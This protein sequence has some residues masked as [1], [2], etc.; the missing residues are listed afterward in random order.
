MKTL[1]LVIACTVFWVAPAS[2]KESAQLL[3]V[4]D[5]DSLLVHYGNEARQVRL[6]GVDAPEGRQEYGKEARAAALRLCYGKPVSLEFDAERKDRYGRLLAYVHCG[7]VMLNEALVGKGLALTIRVKPNVR[8]LERLRLAETRARENRKGFWLRG[9][10]Q[11]TPAQW[12][13][14]N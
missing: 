8:H 14:A 5:G 7:G 4:I 6:I 13:A 1:I 10:L 3:N 9:G 11:K 2:A 12:R